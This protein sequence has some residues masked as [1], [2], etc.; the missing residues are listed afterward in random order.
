M[1]EFHKVFIDQNEETKRH[2]RD[3]PF[4]IFFYWFHNISS[5]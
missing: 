1:P 4:R 2:I 5:E 3:V